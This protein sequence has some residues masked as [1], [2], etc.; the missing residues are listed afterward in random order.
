LEQKI[1]ILSGLLIGIMLFN[2]A[3]EQDVGPVIINS[4]TGPVSFSRDIQL[5]F[6]VNCIG[7]HDEF[8][9]QLDLRSCCSYNQLWT[10]GTGAPYLDTDNPN[11]SKL[12]L[13]LTGELLQMPV[14]GPLPEYDIDMVLKWITE[15]ALDN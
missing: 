9:Q 2:T 4:S 13:H 3:C 1:K 6:D 10:L 14:F 7:C 12:Y 11:Q 8:H 15:G 5:I